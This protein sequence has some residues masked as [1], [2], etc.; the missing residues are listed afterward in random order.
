MNQTRPQLLELLICEVA[1]QRF[2]LSLAE[3]RE[4]IRAVPPVP[5]TRALAPPST[6]GGES[7]A[8]RPAGVEGLINLRG[9]VIPVLDVRSRL[10]LA[11]KP[12][13]HTDHLIIA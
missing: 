13:E 5:V 6:G 1:G 11:A 8:R 3:V 7:R 9:N 4:I 2:G 12:L 10:R